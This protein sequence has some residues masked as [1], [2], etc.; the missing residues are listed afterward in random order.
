VEGSAVGMGLAIM[1][2]LTKQKEK[3][4]TLPGFLLPRQGKVQTQTLYFE[5]FAQF[6]PGWG[7]D[8]EAP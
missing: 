5:D 3:P 2:N 4:G 8:L 7:S 1:L 6:Q